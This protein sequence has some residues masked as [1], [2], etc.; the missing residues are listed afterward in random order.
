MAVVNRA[1]DQL[2]AA[3]DQGFLPAPGLE[4]KPE[5]AGQAPLGE[6]SFT[7][8][9]LPVVAFEAVLMVAVELGDVIQ[10]DEPY[11]LGVL[12]DHPGPATASSTS[13][14]RQGGTTVNLDV[15]PPAWLPRP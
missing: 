11:F 8:D 4:G 15:A 6:A 13:C 2:R 9:G 7:V 3:R 5:A 10:V 1:F 14:P 12:V